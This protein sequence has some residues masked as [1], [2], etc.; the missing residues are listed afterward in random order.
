MLSIFRPETTERM[1]FHSPCYL[2]LQKSKVG[3]PIILELICLL[4][5]VPCYAFHIQKL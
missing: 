4:V 2:H 5:P 3:S 1:D